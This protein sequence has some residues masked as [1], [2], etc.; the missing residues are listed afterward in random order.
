MEQGKGSKSEEGRP[1]TNKRTEVKDNKRI[2]HIDISECV[3]LYQFVFERLSISLFKFQSL[4]L[5][6][7]RIDPSVPPTRQTSRVWNVFHPLHSQ[8]PY[9]IRQLN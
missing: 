7:D 6:L 4:P 5:L 3:C 1:E 8:C 9:A 2:E